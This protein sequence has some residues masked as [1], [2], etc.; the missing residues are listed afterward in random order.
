MPI[1]PPHAPFAE[2][3]CLS[4]CSVAE[5]FYAERVAHT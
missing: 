2:L 1:L 4:K 3:V 5:D